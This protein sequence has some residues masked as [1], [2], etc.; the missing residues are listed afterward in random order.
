MSPFRCLAAFVCAATLLVAPLTAQTTTGIVVGQV[1]DSTG[2]ALPGAQVSVGGTPL[3]AV[4]DVAGGYRLARV[5]AGPQTLTVSYFGFQPQTVEVEIVAGESLRQD[6]RVDLVPVEGETLTVTSEPILEGQARALNQQKNAI[7]IKNVVAADQIGQFPDLNAAEATQRIP[8]VS[9]QRDQGEGRYVLIRGTEARLNSTTLN[10]E[11]VPAPEGDVRN[12]ALDVIPSDLLEAIEVSKALTPDMDGDAIGGTVNLITKMAPSS[13]RLGLDLGLGYN[14]LMEDTGSKAG[15]VYGR[16]SGGRLGLLLAGSALEAD[17]GSDNFE[18]EYDDGDLDT[19]ET[20]DY[21][22]TRERYGA[23]VALD[24]A[25]S[26]RSSWFA[27][28]IWN[29]FDDQEYRRSTIYGVGDGE[30]D[31]ELKDRFES[32]EILSL[33]AGGQSTVGQDLLLEYRVA[34]GSA[35]EREPD[36]YYTTFRQEDVELDPNVSPDAIDPDNIQ[37]NPRN[38]DLDEYVLDEIAVDD[39]D[40]SEDDLVGALDLSLPLSG[41]RLL[42]GYLK[43]GLKMRSRTK[44]RDNRST[45]YEAED[46]IFLADLVDRGFDPGDFLG[47]RYPVG[48]HV[49]PRQA[50]GLLSRFDLEG[51]ID[52]EEETADYEADEQTLAGYLMAELP[53]GERLK[54]VPGVRYESTDIEY[55]GKRVTFDDEGDLLGIEPVKGESSYGELLPMAHLVWR[56]GE[57]SNLRAAVTRTLSRPNYFDLAPYELVLEEDREIERGNPRLDVTTA[58]NYD[59]MAERYFGSLGLVSAGVFYKSFSDYIYVFRSEEEIG[60]DTFEV[61]QPRNGESAKLWG[62]ELAFQTQFRAL[63]APLDGLGLYLNYT[64]TDSEAEFPDREGEKA[65]LPGQSESLGN[66]A[67]SYEKRGF[68]SRFSLNYHGKYIDA[69]GGSPAEDVY[70]DDHFQLDVSASQRLTDRL[71]LTLELIN[72]TDEPLRYY[73]GSSDRPIQEEYYSWW[74]TLGLKWSLF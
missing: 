7:N 34:Y 37:A 26:A 59:L 56:V 36:A 32:Q 27:R 63:P 23:T 39:N 4:T 14:D 46:D 15:F 72:L 73:E 33:S 24:D 22:I 40:T 31:R 20:R 16:R 57:T 2:G 38:E 74:G 70:Y 68:S 50:R 61:T 66:V 18:A 13:P 10:G 8:G 12:V 17:R 41:E 60:G 1:T 55:E 65:T 21:T 6:V 9:I 11:R 64:W 5:P 25:P 51:E 69:V 43:T 3:A 53:L 58:W 30:I 62:V 19:L 44:E 52:P 71:R 67:L 47:G 42:G 54:L 49:D 35:G 45:V 28:G 48:P 29:R